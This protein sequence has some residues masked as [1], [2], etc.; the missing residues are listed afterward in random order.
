MDLT[1]PSK[2]KVTVNRGLMSSVDINVNNENIYSA[3][4]DTVLNDFFVGIDCK[5]PGGYYREVSIKDLTTEYVY[6]E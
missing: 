2:I 1:Q 5:N 3:I 6:V 4:H